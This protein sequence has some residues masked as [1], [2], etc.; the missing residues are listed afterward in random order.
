LFLIIIVSTTTIMEYFFLSFLLK[1]WGHEIILCFLLKKKRLCLK[2]AT[3]TNGQ[4]IHDLTRWL[5]TPWYNL[6][7]NTDRLT[8]EWH[9][10]SIMYQNEP[11]QRTCKSRHDHED[12]AIIWL[13]AVHKSS[14][15]RTHR[16]QIKLALEFRFKNLFPFFIYFGFNFQE[17]D[18]SLS[19]C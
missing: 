4:K 2:K 5:A 15:R 7:E 8:S 18:Y 11:V 14:S 16:F 12:T 6:F 17:Y 19:V 13:H 9:A 1:R 10:S 3:R